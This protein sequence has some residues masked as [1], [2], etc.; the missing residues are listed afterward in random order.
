VSADET[1]HAE[2]L[3]RQRAKLAL[4]NRMRA[5]REALP[6]SACEARSS[7]ITTRLLSLVELERAS[8][9][10]V[11]ASIRNEV[12]T[13]RC[14][15]AAWAA[16]KHVALP[17]VI[18]DELRL[19]AV[20]AETE[21]VEGALGVPEPPADAPRVEPGDVGFALVP[22]LA[23]DPRGYRIGYGGGY[24]DKLI[25]QLRNA[26]TCAVA[27]DFQLISEVPELP[28]DVPVDLVVTDERVIRTN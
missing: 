20:A 13:Q 26:C 11:F 25:P 1:G 19:Y 28:H 4:R 18:E 16:G 10:L 5:V 7:E 23:V 8:T 12:R 27:Y 14:M 3:L 9:V 15:H 24:Y 21:L 6:G 2:G 22:A 17:R